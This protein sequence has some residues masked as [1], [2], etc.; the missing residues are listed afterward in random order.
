MLRLSAVPMALPPEE[1][2]E[3]QRLVRAQKTPR[4][5]A[6]RSE[7]I[8]RSA[9]E[10][11]SREIA[12]HPDVWPETVRVWRARGLAGPRQLLVVFRLEV[13]PRWGELATFSPEQ[14]CAI[15]TQACEKPE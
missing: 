8:F 5:L 11:S 2:L 9:A 10:T 15:M 7:M 14:V 3:L 13:A 4:N 1:E 12:R 6:E